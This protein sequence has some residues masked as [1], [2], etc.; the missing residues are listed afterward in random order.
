MELIN[1]ELGGGEG[2]GKGTRG[3]SITLI[4]FHSLGLVGGHQLSLVLL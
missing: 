3:A 1:T 2:L 4:M